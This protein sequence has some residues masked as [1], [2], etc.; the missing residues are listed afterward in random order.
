M[1]KLILCRG[2]SVLADLLKDQASSIGRGKLVGAV[3]SEE[4]ANAL[5]KLG[6]PVLQLD[7][8][9]EKSLAEAIL[10]H[11]SEHGISNLSK[12]RCLT[13][14]LPVN[15]VIHT[16]SAIDPTT[17]LNLINALAKQGEISGKKT[18][19]IHVSPPHLFICHNPNT[20]TKTDVGAK[21]LL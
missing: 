16:V 18:F 7:L 4:Q 5:A 15:I 21:C 10:D 19:F 3:R 20:D 11:D 13:E 12:H 9:N 2:G 1:R 14:N 6:I 8:T 17:A